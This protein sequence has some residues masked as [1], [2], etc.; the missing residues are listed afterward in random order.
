VLEY[1][2]KENQNFEAS[3]MELQPSPNMNNCENTLAIN[4]DEISDS[5]QGT[6]MIELFSDDNQPIVDE[7]IKPTSKYEIVGEKNHHPS[8]I[9]INKFK[10][11]SDVP[12]YKRTVIEPSAKDLKPW[13]R[14]K[15]K[16]G[17]N[18][19]FASHTIQCSGKRPHKEILNRKS[20][21]RSLP[22]VENPV[23]S[24]KRKF[25]YN[26]I[27]KNVKSIECETT[28]KALSSTE[29]QFHSEYTRTYMRDTESVKNRKQLTKK[30]KVSK[31]TK[32][33]KMNIR[34]D[35]QGEVMNTESSLR[36]SKESISLRGSIH[37]KKTP[38]NDSC[39]VKLSG[40]STTKPNTLANS[41]V[42]KGL[43]SHPTSSE[44]NKSHKLKE[45]KNIMRN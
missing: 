44:A 25:V 4:S 31:K 6:P 22:K 38:L 26:Y 28:E 11:F 32:T 3:P 29:K 37:S 42:T 17:L 18:K 12:V 24:K 35:G 14:N 45:K 8:M 19:N 20:R 36:N 2:Y 1:Q 21:K 16:D 23:E 43:G 30:P 5:N 41:D 7:Y 40:M 39:E 34:E 33:I 13:T 15:N 27:K 9:E 10:T